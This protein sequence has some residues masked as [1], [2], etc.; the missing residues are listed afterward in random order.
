[1]AMRH[2]KKASTTTLIRQALQTAYDTNPYWA[3]IQVLWRRRPALPTFQAALALCECN[4]VRGRCLGADILQRLA[5]D[6]KQHVFPF[7]ERS[8]PVLDRLL[9]DPNDDV[10]VLA[11]L[12]IQQLGNISAAR[13]VPL[14]AHANKWVRF[15][16]I[17]A[18]SIEDDGA[19]LQTVIAL[20][21]DEAGMVRDWATFRLATSDV[22]STTVRD[23]L[24]MRL[25][26][27]DQDARGEAI[28]GLARRG[29]PRV[30]VAIEPELRYQLTRE[31][32]NDFAVE[33]AAAMPSLAYVPALRLLL[34]RAP[35]SSTVSSALAKCEASSQ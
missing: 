17:D 9:D 20:S 22:D 26:D 3:R 27:L 10:V 19:A 25:T 2:L 15:F 13:I 8:T 16:V 7:A 35:E 30:V 28:A 4:D 33:A 12:A 31:R 1:M 24:A 6:W 5:A 11:L 32:P 23:A 34:A 14:A 18:L 29:D 21:R